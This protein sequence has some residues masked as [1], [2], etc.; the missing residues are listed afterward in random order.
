MKWWYRIYFCLT[1]GI[2]LLFGCMIVLTPNR[3][4]SD[5]ENR[6]LSSLPAFHLLDFWTG[7]YQENL[8]QAADDQMVGRDQFTALAADLMRTMG[9]RDIGGVYLGSEQTYLTRTLA[10]DIEMFRYMENLRYVEYLSGEYPK[11]VSL[12]LVPSAGTIL[13][14]R[15]PKYA[16]FYHADSMYRAA[17]V[18]CETANVLDLR[19]AMQLQN[20]ILRGEKSDSEVYFRTDHHWTLPG[21]YQ[22]YTVYSMANQREPMEY[23]EFQPEKITDS[24][25][26]TLYSKVLDQRIK[27]DVMYVATKIGETTSVVCDGN[28]RKSVYDPEKLDTKDKYAYFFG[29]NYSKV[30]I[31]TKADQGGTLVIFKDSFA[32][33][34]VPFMLQDYEEIIMIDLRY[35]RESVNEWLEELEDP[36]ILIL[37][38]MSN[39]AQDA[40]L[41]KLSK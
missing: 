27:P 24:F 31:Q 26:G 29:G 17:D 34:M 30:N 18:V 28:K 7:D 11:K 13:Q 8:E 16:P 1:A 10:D 41:V 5:N 2:L 20:Q 15:L 3:I 33:S 22:G 12:M 14:D 39:F 23:Q 37:Y 21:A 9:Y 19:K 32:N 35:F 4:F 38:E 6:V 25:Y 40:N 36:E